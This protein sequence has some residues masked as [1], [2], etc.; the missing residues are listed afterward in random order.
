MSQN[1]ILRT[2]VRNDNNQPI[3]VVVP[4]GR[5]QIGYS[6]CNVKKGDKFNKLFGYD[7]AVGRSLHPRRNIVAFENEI[8]RLADL[9]HNIY[10]M[11]TDGE[12]SS[13]KYFQLDSEFDIL[14]ENIGQEFANR[15]VP[16]KA[17]P[18]VIKMSC[19]AIRYFPKDVDLDYPNQPV[20]NEM[21]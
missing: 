5:N 10:N 12:E 18:D 15:G 1:H 11:Q 16:L 8:V 9:W 19:R 4:T 14:Y 13:D 7:I 2:Y 6:V 3:G 17:I 20:K 21:I